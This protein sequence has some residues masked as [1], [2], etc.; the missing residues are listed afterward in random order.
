ME[1]LFEFEKGKVFDEKSKLYRFQCDCITPAD[2]MDIMA[3]SWGKDDEGKF[4]TISLYF[5]GTSLWDRI[6][7]AFQILRGHWSWRE[8]IPR[9]EDYGNLSEIFDPDKKYSE[10]P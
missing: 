9:P 5:Y 4:I 10:L 1:K 8:F 7:Y 3:E 6:K 2:A